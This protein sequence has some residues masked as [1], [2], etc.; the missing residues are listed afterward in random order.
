MRSRTNMSSVILLYGKS[1]NALSC[2]LKSTSSP[3]SVART[4]RL[5]P[6]SRPLTSEVVALIRRAPGLRRLHRIFVRRVAA[7]RFDSIWLKAE[8]IEHLGHE[9]AELRAAGHRVCRGHVVVWRRSLV[10]HALHQI[11][12]PTRR[13]RVRG[14]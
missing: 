7:P 11:D 2:G 13:P 1:T 6:R 4:M 8:T 12:E 3:S 10:F 5:V 9:F 14:G